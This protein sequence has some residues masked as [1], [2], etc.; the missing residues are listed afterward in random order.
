VAA[1]EMPE[2]EELGRWPDIAAPLHVSAMEACTGGN[3]RRCTPMGVVT[4]D[5]S[6]DRIG[7]SPAT[8]MWVLAVALAR[9]LAEVT[10][11]SVVFKMES[12]RCRLQDGV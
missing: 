10:M 5:C 9:P 7:G 1:I 8:P 3:S 6:R 11:L 12:S 4:M 2:L